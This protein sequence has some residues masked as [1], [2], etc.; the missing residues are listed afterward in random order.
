VIREEE[1]PRP[2]TRLSESKD[3][4]PSISA[5]RQTEPVKLTK[6]VRGELD[7]IVMKALEKDRGRRYETANGFAQD[8]Q[9][10]LADEPVEACPPSAGYRLRKFARKNKKALV[11]AGAFMVLLA[12]LGA[13]A[14]WMLND[15][16]ARQREADAKVWEAESRVGEA[17]EEA[18]PGLRDGNP[19]DRA[20]IAAAQRVQA[21]LDSSA[22]GPDVRQRAEQFLADVRMLAELEE[23][24]MRLADTKGGGAFDYSGTEARY[25]A[26]FPKY[27]LDVLA[28]DPAEAA[29]RIRSSAIREALLVGLYDWITN[30]HQWTG[31]NVVGVE[32]KHE[33]KLVHVRQV[34]EAADDN[35]W[36]RTLLAAAL[37]RAVPKLKVLVKQREALEQRGPVLAWVGLVLWFHLELQGILGESLMRQAQQRH[38]A[39]FWINYVLANDLYWVKRQPA[40][41]VGYCRAAVAMRPSSAEARNLLGRALMDRGDLDS[42]IATFQQAVVLQPKYTFVPISLAEALMRK[43]EA[44][45][46]KGDV[47]GAIQEYREALRFNKDNAV[48]H[49][50]LGIAL[51]DKGQLEEA[52]AEFR[53]TIR[54]NKDFAEAHNNLGNVLSTKGLV[55]EAIAEY[56]EAIRLKKDFVQAQLNRAIVYAASGQGAKAIGDYERVIEAAQNN[57]ALRPAAYNH[58]AWFL[59]TCP[60]AKFRDPKRAVELAQ[61]AVELAPTDLNFQNT[62]GVAYYR[63]GDAKAALAALNKSVTKGGTAHDWFF[64]AMVHRALGDREEAQKWYDKAVLWLEKNSQAMAQDPRRVSDLEELRRFRSEAEEALELEKK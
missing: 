51:R 47:D 15:R 64:L 30:L 56:G 6:L 9:R 49:N 12:A 38:P 41:A 32:P 43:A 25:A 35:A 58:L 61:K 54:L 53:A 26:L 16:A 37:A 4:L 42:A 5:Q 27:G 57:R 59:S 13:G 14:G 28:L 33:P 21:L 44:L 50:N 48:A 2:S 20:L 46:R 22:I 60:E 1:P 34:A 19:E 8:V 55:D 3:S 62:L 10:Y 52:I 29:A 31:V 36:R 7:W 17:L 11:T 24:H 63:L 40:E 45:L 23:I 39:D 18:K